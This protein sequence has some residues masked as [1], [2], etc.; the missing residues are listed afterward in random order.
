MA[1]PH[2]LICI[3]A[4]DWLPYLLCPRQEEVDVLART[5]V[6]LPGNPSRSVIPPLLRR[7]L[8]ETS[9]L[10]E[11]PIFKEVL[12][13][14]LDE[15]FSYLVDRKIAVQAFRMDPAE[16]LADSARLTA[17]SSAGTATKLASVLAVFAKQAHAIGNNGS[18]STAAGLGGGNEYLGVMES[19]SDL[20][21]F[22]AV[23]Y[24][25]NFEHEIPGPETGDSGTTEY[26]IGFPPPP[27]YPEELENERWKE[28]AAN[29]SQ[30][31]AG[32]SATDDRS[33]DVSKSETGKSGTGDHSLEAAWEKANA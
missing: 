20:E 13:T 32:K 17:G 26:P 11:S 31:V 9:D 10:L 30:G 7:L 15:T 29:V 19:I 12:T 3:R 27:I 2:P 16:P 18:L 6:L 24:S 21:A 28:S 25:S 5:G 23:I 14:T 22:S 1:S 33:A 4:K 8:D